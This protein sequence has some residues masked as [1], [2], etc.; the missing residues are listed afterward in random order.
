MLRE[1]LLSFLVMSFM[2]SPL[3][4]TASLVDTVI[5]AILIMIGSFMQAT[6]PRISP[7]EFNSIFCWNC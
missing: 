6:V 5:T 2:V 4:V 3:L 7:V 1:A